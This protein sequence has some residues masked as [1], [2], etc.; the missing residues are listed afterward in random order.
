MQVSEITQQHSYSRCSQVVIGP[1]YQLSRESTLLP[2]CVNVYNEPQHIVAVL[3][4]CVVCCHSIR[5]NFKLNPNV[6]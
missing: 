1:D 2:S 5:P 6:S 3:R 4:Q